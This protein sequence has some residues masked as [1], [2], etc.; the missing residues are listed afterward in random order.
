[1]KFPKAQEAKEISKCQVAAAFA[2]TGD[3]EQYAQDGSWLNII[4]QN[5]KTITLPYIKGITTRIN[6]IF[7]IYFNTTL[8]LTHYNTLH[9][10]ILQ[11][12]RKW[13]YYCIIIFPELAVI[14]QFS[15]AHLWASI[16]KIKYSP[17][18][19]SG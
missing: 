7:H 18:R 19:I 6:Y 14:H 3:P 10:W 1:M 16:P 4:K 8:T 13:K 12:E 11:H 9:Y 5:Q 15:I 17:V 2:S